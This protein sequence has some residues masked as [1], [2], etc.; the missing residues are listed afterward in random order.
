M[1]RK[2]GVSMKRRR[3]YHGAGTLAFQ[4]APTFLGTLFFFV[5]GISA[6]VFTELMMSA[7]EKE[8]LLSFVKQQLFLPNWSRGD[9][10]EI[11]IHSVG[12][13]MGLLLIIVLSGITAIG[14][15]A[16]LVAMAYKGMALGFSSALLIE[17]MDQ[18][19]F[20]LIL[21]A[22]ILPNLLLLP[23]LLTACAASVNLAFRTLNHRRSGMKKSLAES[24]DSYVFLNLILAAVILA[25]CVAESLISPFVSRLAG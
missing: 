5:L 8:S 9:L 25:G 3:K 4:S 19:G 2:E 23:A 14:F 6:G 24:A 7:V 18:K 1:W 21:A 22:M 10:P 15:P 16:A 11:F 12:N 20:F 17:S 13:N